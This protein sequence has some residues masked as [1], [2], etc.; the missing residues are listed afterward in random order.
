MST[1]YHY[2]ENGAPPHA[3]TGLNNDHTR[4]GYDAAGQQVSAV[5]RAVEYTT[6]GLPKAV[7]YGQNQ[8]RREFDYDA[9]G[10]R[11]RKDDVN[12]TLV[13]VG[14][15]VERSVAHPGGE[16]PPDARG[17]QNVHNILAE[18]RVVAQVVWKQDTVGGAIVQR[19]V[20]YPH[21]DALGSTVVVSAGGGGPVST[22]FYD[23]WG[24]RTDAAGR[25]TS[26]NEGQPRQGFTGHEHDDDLGLI[27]AKG[28]IYDPVHR[29]FLSPDPVV[30]DPRASQALN[31]YAYVQNNPAT[32]TDPTGLTCVSCN[33]GYGPSPMDV[34]QVNPASYV[35]EIIAIY[36]PGSE[37][38]V[39]INLAAIKADDDLATTPGPT[40]QNKVCKDCAGTPDSTGRQLRRL[41]RDPD[42]AAV[43]GTGGSSFL[44]ANPP[45]VLDDVNTTTTVLNVPAWMAGDGE[46]PIAKTISALDKVADFF[47][48]TVF[49]A[50]DLAEADGPLE[51]AKGVGVLGSAL[52]LKYGIVMEYAAGKG[53]ITAS[54]AL[55]VGR[56]LLWTGGVGEVLAVLELAYQVYKHREEI[57]AATNAAISRGREIVKPHMDAF[58]KYIAPAILDIGLQ[59]QG[60]SL[61]EVQP[62]WVRD[63][64]LGNTERYLP[65]GDRDMWRR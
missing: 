45:E 25:P 44:L 35:P 50:K 30:T 40:A 21:T 65:D 11:V 57:A 22:F 20:Q 4:F 53:F 23:P 33:P 51:A 56:V 3:L 61:K 49:A 32:R 6:K 43:Q 41:S 52:A 18:G 46:G 47:L 29:R 17:V 24:Q 37:K 60:S 64:E 1:T 59:L 38:V 62:P 26:R 63:A 7:T 15:L 2:G 16:T 55:L 42:A 28:R 19:G 34:Y 10:A 9:D 27:N 48:G 39:I 12:K 14:G 54:R 58:D 31:R 36:Q 8:I 13:T 5:R